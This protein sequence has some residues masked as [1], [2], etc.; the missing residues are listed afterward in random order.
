MFTG[1]VWPGVTAFPDF[2]NPMAAVYWKDQ[3]G[4]TCVHHMYS[5]KTIILYLSKVLSVLH[6]YILKYLLYNV[7]VY[8]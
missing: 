7:C 1:K 5:I 3:V 4:T 6:V 2:F 8:V